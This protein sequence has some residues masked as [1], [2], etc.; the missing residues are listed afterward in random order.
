MW[1]YMDR[2]GR[3][4]KERFQDKRSLVDRR[5]FNYSIVFP[6]RR[7]NNN[8]RIADRRTKHISLGKLI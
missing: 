7:N 5:K 4:M 8:R 6:D 1:F 2:T 3:I